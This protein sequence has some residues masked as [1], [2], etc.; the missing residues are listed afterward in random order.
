MNY[1]WLPIQKVNLP[2]WEETCPV[3][4]FRILLQD[5]FTNLLSGVLPGKLTGKYNSVLISGVK[6]P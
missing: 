3:G 5:Q 4:E 1:N 2:K 6:I